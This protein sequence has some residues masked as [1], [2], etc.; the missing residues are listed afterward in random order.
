MFRPL[1]EFVSLYDLTLRTVTLL[2]LVSAQRC[3]SLHLLDV[4][5]MPVLTDRF[6][7]CLI[8]NVKLIIIVL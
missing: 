2:A 3:Q 6:V 8:G 7:F 5:F 4:Q 1:V